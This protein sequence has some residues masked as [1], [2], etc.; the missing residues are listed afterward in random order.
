MEDFLSGLL[1]AIFE[2]LLEALFEVVLGEVAAATSR[3]LRRSRVSIRRADPRVTT[4]VFASV[5]LGFGFLSAVMFPHPLV[6][7]SSSMASAC[8]SAR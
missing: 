6:H 7:P 8:S 4:F 2:I 3:A 5:G 1:G